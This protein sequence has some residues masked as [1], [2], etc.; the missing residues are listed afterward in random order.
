MTLDGSACPGGNKLKFLDQA[1]LSMY[2]GRLMPIISRKAVAT[3]L[4][5]F[6]VWGLTACSSGGSNSG[7]SQPTTPVVTP[8]ATP[9]VASISPAKLAAGVAD[10]SLTVTGTNFTSPSA[11]QVGS[12]VEPTTY[13]SATQL[14]ATISASQL[15]P[16]R[17]SR[18]SF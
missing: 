8:V 12:V 1:Q 9:T 6:S 14:T 3:L 16:D 11:V 18:S 7:G 2:A 17:V 5:S 13:V 4:V 10:T 15:A